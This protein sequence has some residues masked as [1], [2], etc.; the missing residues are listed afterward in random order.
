M[1]HHARHD[2][3]SAFESKFAEHDLEGRDAHAPKQLLMH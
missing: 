1:H 3:L 2:E